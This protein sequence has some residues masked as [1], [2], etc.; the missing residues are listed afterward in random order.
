MDA[1]TLPSDSQPPEQSPTPILTGPRQALLD[2]LHQSDPKSAAFYLG[3]LRVLVDQ[4]NPE[5]LFQA[6]HSIRELLEKA[7]VLAGGLAAPSQRLNDKL[8]SLR[9]KFRKLTPHLEEDG[10]W[11]PNSEKKVAAVLQE[12]RSVVEWMDANF[13]QRRDETRILLRALTG[14]GILLPSD[15]EEAE[16]E[17]FME[18]KQYFT[19]LSHHRFSATNEDFHQKLTRAETILL[20]K[21]RPEPAADFAAIDA[22][23]KAAGQ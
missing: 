20:R 13:K 23:L 17:E 9:A 16:I 8:G 1:P 7:P 2:A 22:L 5:R 11:A 18:L 6:A 15:V 10:T 14:P 12:L 19:E 4:Q 21:L 3:A